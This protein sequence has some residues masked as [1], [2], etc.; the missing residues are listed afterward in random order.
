MEN[1]NF[2]KAIKSLLMILFIHLVLLQTYKSKNL[3]LKV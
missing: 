3:F 1:V 2:L